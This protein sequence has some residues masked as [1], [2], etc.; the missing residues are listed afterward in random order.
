V[1]ALPPR[2][3]GH[4]AHVTRLQATDGPACLADFA[5]A[6]MADHPEAVLCELDLDR[7]AMCSGTEDDH[8]RGVGRPI[9]SRISSARPSCL[10]IARLFFLTRERICRFVVARAN[11]LL[12]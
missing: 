11:C 1:L 2:D 6:F 10:P 7:H 9:A 4:P 5:Q 12:K 3:R 8:R